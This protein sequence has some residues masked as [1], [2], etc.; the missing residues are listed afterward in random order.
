MHKYAHKVIQVVAVIS[1]LVSGVK[2]AN[3][4]SGEE[5]KKWKWVVW[6]VPPCEYNCDPDVAGCAT[7]PDC[8]CDCYR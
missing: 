4:S 3:A 5:T 2:A 7:N 6:I 1:L 8:G